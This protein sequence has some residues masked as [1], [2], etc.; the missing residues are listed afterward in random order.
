MSENKSIFTG[1]LASYLEA[2][3]TE[4]RTL[5]CRYIEEERLAHEFDILS[6]QFDCSEGM[7]NGLVDEFIKFKPNWQATTQK[8]HI[9]FVQNFGRYLINHD[10][11]AFLPGYTSLRKAAS[12]FK[13]CICQVKIP[14]HNNRKVPHL[15]QIKKLL[16][17]KPLFG[18]FVPIGIPIHINNVCFMC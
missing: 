12:C 15:E 1:T 10:I 16:F 18:F 2:F 17:L 6:L 8:R 5:G 7:S 13:P 9:S 4:K 3:I 11:N 14:P